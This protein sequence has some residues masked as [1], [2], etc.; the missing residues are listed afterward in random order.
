MINSTFS[1][2]LVLK[3]LTDEAFQMGKKETAAE[4]GRN[5]LIFAL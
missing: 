3:E 5:L 1:L 4:G 2:P